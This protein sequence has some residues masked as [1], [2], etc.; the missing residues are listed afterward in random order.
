VHVANGVWCKTGICCTISR[1]SAG[2]DGGV[3]FAGG[4]VQRGSYE[5][6]AG[7]VHQSGPHTDV[8][9]AVEYPTDSK[10]PPPYHSWGSWVPRG[11]VMGTE[12]SPSAQVEMWI[13]VMSCLC[14]GLQLWKV[15]SVWALTAKERQNNILQCS[16]YFV[17]CHVVL[18]APERESGT[19]TNFV[20]LSICAVHPF[21]NKVCNSLLLQIFS[22]IEC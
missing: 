16:S 15:I 22:W 20:C 10:V 17:V 21:W 3:A 7:G 8:P 11:W 13:Y 1:S 5:D 4:K 6:I 19:E 9:S 14:P 12:P 2:T 18:F